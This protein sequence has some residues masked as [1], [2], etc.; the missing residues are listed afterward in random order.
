MLADQLLK[1]WES[2]T[3]LNSTFSYDESWVA[4]RMLLP[5]AVEHWGY[6]R[7]AFFKPEAQFALNPQKDDILGRTENYMVPG[8]KDQLRNEKTMA[9]R[10]DL[11]LFML[12]GGL[13]GPD[14]AIGRHKAVEYSR[15]NPKHVAVLT[16]FHVV[17]IYVA[18]QLVRQY[19]IWD[20]ERRFEELSS[21][22]KPK[23]YEIPAPLGEDE[24]AARFSA[25]IRD[26]Y[27]ILAEEFSGRKNT[28][29]L[30][31]GK[32]VPATAAVQALAYIVFLRFLEERYPFF[33]S[34]LRRFYYSYLGDG[35]QAY[36]DVCLTGH[37][38]VDLNHVIR[39]MRYGEIL[40]T[41][42]GY[43]F[44]DQTL[45]HKLWKMDVSNEGMLRVLEP[46]VKQRYSTLRAPLSGLLFGRL[47]QRVRAGASEDQESARPPLLAAF[48][49]GEA[50]KPITVADLRE[51]LDDFFVKRLQPAFKR[52][53]PDAFRKAS[54]DFLAI[55]VAEEH[56]GGPI[57]LACAASCLMAV[58]DRVQ[59]L[60]QQWLTESQQKT[61]TLFG[62][63]E[64]AHLGQGC[65]AIPEIFR[66]HLYWH[67]QAAGDKEL[68][69]LALNVL[70]VIRAD[71]AAPYPENLKSLNLEP[72]PTRKRP[73]ADTS[74]E[75]SGGLEIKEE[76]PSLVADP[77]M[78]SPSG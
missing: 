39:Y 72:L 43:E 78:E 42:V 55:R 4:G 62:A 20:W 77:G 25:A 35:F 64:I 5:I 76:E 29:I 14:T 53:D 21:I 69:E 28:R 8:L 37:I 65:N 10:P 7:E 61:Q 9:L 2:E 32:L 3:V 19:G 74:S 15:Q 16:S 18:G 12:R 63:P 38:W 13:Y 75:P 27:P 36:A 58:H 46:L 50:F 51:R 59:S 48:S 68:A 67:Y 23:G 26:M 66:H 22:F 44:P 70:S 41:F 60:R 52:R 49:L 57:Y 34:Q 54:A 40:D 71:E 45:R 47:L 24:E 1:L 31:G 6:P 56:K 11:R 73:Q 33:R 30:A 17:D